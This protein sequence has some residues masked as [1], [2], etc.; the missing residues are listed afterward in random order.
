MAAE[1]INRDYALE[2]YLRRKVEREIPYSED[3]AER[4]KLIHDKLK[5]ALAKTL[6]SPGTNPD[7]FTKIEKPEDA[8]TP[9]HPKI[10]ENWGQPGWG[11]YYEFRPKKN[12]PYLGDV[13][14]E[15]IAAIDRL[16]ELKK[17]GQVQGVA[18]KFQKALKRP[19]E[20]WKSVNQML[21]EFMDAKLSILEKGISKG[22]FKRVAVP[23]ALG[24][25]EVVQIVDE[26][27][28]STVGGAKAAGELY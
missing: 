10:V 6:L 1:V 13:V 8:K 25:F 2:V 18:K 21:Y 5:K 12:Q 28:A 24:E 22:H 14:S 3:K 20:D 17:E 26:I 4:V 15:F 9:L 16:L 27:G 7:S 23:G 11:P 19:F